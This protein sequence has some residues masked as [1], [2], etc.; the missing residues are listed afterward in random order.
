[1]KVLVDVADDRLGELLGGGLASQVLRSHFTI[2][3]HPC[4]GIRYQFAVC[5][6]IYVTQHLGATEKHRCRISDILADSLAECMSGSL[7]KQNT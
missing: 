6:Q 3:E 2:G 7:Q 1:M 5:R 4:Y